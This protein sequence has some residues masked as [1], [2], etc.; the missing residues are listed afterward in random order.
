LAYKESLYLRAADDA[1]VA[2]QEEIDALKL[3][4]DTL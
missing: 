4:I 1:K 2:I 3:S